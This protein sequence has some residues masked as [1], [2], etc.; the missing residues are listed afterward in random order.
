MSEGGPHLGDRSLPFKLVS[1]IWSRFGRAEQCA[2]WS[3]LSTWDNPGLSE[4]NMQA[5]A[6]VTLPNSSV[7][8]GA[9]FMHIG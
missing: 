3:Y 7:G 1:K 2:V 4:R 5:Q 6:R 9:G 8:F